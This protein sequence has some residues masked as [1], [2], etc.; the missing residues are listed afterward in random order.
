MADLNNVDLAIDDWEA[1]ADAA[2]DIATDDSDHGAAA[3]AGYQYWDTDS[4]RSDRLTW[5]SPPIDPDVSARAGAPYEDE[6]F[7]WRPRYS[8]WLGNLVHSA[9]LYLAHGRSPEVKE[10]ENPWDPWEEYADGENATQVPE[11]SATEQDLEPEDTSYATQMPEPSATEQ[12]L[13]PKDTLI[14]TAQTIA[15]PAPSEGVNGSGNRLPADNLDVFA[16]ILGWLVPRISE[17]PVDGYFRPGGPGHD[18]LM[19]IKSVTH[20]CRLWRNTTMQLKATVWGPLVAAARDE[21]SW[22]SALEKAGEANI[23]VVYCTGVPHELCDAELHRASAVYAGRD[24]EWRNFGPLLTDA[25]LKNLE[26]LYLCPN[27]RLMP[28]SSLRMYGPLEAP[29]LRICVTATPFLLRAPKLRYLGLQHQSRTQVLTVLSGLKDIPLFWLAIDRPREPGVIDA[30]E[31]VRAVTTE[32]LRFL[33]IGASTRQFAILDTSVE[34][35]SCPSLEI[36]DVC[37][38]SWLAAPR[39]DIAQVFGAHP[40]EVLSMLSRARNVRVLRTK[41]RN[42]WSPEFTPALDVPFDG[43]SPLALPRLEKLEIVGI[44]A[45][46]TQQFLAGLSAPNLAEM[47]MFCDMPPQP[48]HQVL[49]TSRGALH[50][51][52]QSIDNALSGRDDLAQLLIST[53]NNLRAAGQDGVAQIMTRTPNFPQ[54]WTPA[55]WPNV[56]ELRAMTRDFLDSLAVAIESPPAPHNGHLL[57]EVVQAA[58]LAAALSA[59]DAAVMKIKSNR[60]AAE[61]LVSYRD[62]A[63]TMTFA[64]VGSRT[65]QWATSWET[66]GDSMLYGVA[67]MLFGLSV[68]QTREL[69]V[70]GEPFASLWPP[71]GPDVDALL[72]SLR[73]YAMVH[74]LCVD[75]A[76]SYMTANPCQFLRVIRDATVL[77]SLRSAVVRCAPKWS[78]RTRIPQVDARVAAVMTALKEVLE[79]RMAEGGPLMALELEGACCIPAADVKTLKG[80]VNSVILSTVCIRAENRQLCSVCNEA[81]E[82]T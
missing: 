65:N 21:T 41:W 19:S 71:N 68:A 80:L 67:R 49:V 6:D 15:S 57:R 27:R 63:C 22:Q 18:A 43:L 79:S 9:H 70:V 14:D 30:S 74:T 77:P 37:G 26:V 50:A 16:Y 34:P 4:A 24:L 2:S 66:R 42:P 13:E 10:D 33:R 64:M 25:D 32:H 60:D 61:F 31:I 62:G 69:H 78:D 3:E 54:A 11:S 53:R 29:A 58:M 23:R 73:E 52:L 46:E 75:Y 82:C 38:P 59:D 45:R 8:G 17:T 44:M 72:Q 12:E 20:S 76:Y 1:D 47:Q 39:L 48:V 28:K 56:A 55:E 81:N 35:T 36:A 51:E 40:G 5:G 7:G